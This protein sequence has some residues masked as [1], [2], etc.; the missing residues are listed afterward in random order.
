M[1]HWSGTRQH[2][3]DQ[4]LECTQ[5]ER[6]TEHH[7][8]REPDELQRADSAADEQIR[9]LG[10][11]VEQ[12]L[13]ERQAAEGRQLEDRTHLVAELGVR[14]AHLVERRSRPKNP[15]ITFAPS[16]PSAA[17]GNWCA[18]PETATS[19]ARLLPHRYFVV[20]SRP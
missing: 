12:R 6:R 4:Q 14:R 7:D 20:T 1:Q 5:H 17:D 15:A 11:Q 19:C 10:Q 16:S 8:D 3:P 9:V 2:C 18:P 13:R